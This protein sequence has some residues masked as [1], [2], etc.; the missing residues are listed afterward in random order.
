MI[1]ST[2]LAVSV[3]IISFIYFKVM[4]TKGCCMLFVSWKLVKVWG[5]SRPRDWQ[6]DF[7]DALSWRNN[8]EMLSGI[9]KGSSGMHHLAVA[10][11][12]NYKG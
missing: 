2:A 12:S 8:I 11:G 10:I 3:L 4:A 1:E 6:L 7:F 9:Y 5:P